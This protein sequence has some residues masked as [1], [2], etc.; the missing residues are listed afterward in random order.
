MKKKLII[1]VAAIL[2]FS[3]SFQSCIGSFSLTNKVL[4]WN[5]HVNNKFVNELVFFVFWV[6]PVYEVTAIADLLVINSIEFWS[7]NKP[8][9]SANRTIETEHG[10]YQILA[11]AA[12]YTLLAPDGRNMR[13]DFDTPSQTWSFSID[14]G[15]KTDFMKFIDDSHVQM[16]TQDG[17]FVD[18]ELS[19]DGVRNYSASIMPQL[20]AAR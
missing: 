1:P 7:G 17:D 15:D 10:N 20:M 2:L 19:E 14:N 18:V 4:T 12:G 13:F 16:I 11:D 6:L 8:L 9:E 5:R 3:L